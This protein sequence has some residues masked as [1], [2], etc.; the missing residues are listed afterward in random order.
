MLMYYGMHYFVGL[1]WFMLIIKI[2]VIALLVYVIYRLFKRSD[3][4]T[5]LIEK[6]RSLQILKERF[7][8]GEISEEEY[9]RI[10]EILMGD[11]K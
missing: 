9:T 2:V 10:R 7:A 11:K 3:V 4:R 6:D 8:R 5:H 1:F